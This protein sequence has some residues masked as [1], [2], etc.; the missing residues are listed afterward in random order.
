MFKTPYLSLL[1]WAILVFCPAAAQAQQPDLSTWIQKGIKYYEK[2]EHPLY[3][4]LEE[5]SKKMGGHGGIDFMMLFR[6]V[7]CLRQG[8]PLDQNLYEGCFWSAVSPLSERSVASGGS[9]NCSPILQGATG[10][11]P[12]L[13]K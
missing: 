10:K 7:E 5:V 12:L 9:P 1:F 13:W 4:R 6:I 8:Q 3:V 2:Y 11:T